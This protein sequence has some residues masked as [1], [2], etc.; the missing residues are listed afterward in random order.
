MLIEEG[1]SDRVL[2]RTAGNLIGYTHDY[3][4]GLPETTSRIGK[5]TD[6]VK[7]VNRELPGRDQADEVWLRWF[8][9]FER[10]LSPLQKVNTELEKTAR[11]LRVRQRSIM[12]SMSPAGMFSLI[13]STAHFFAKPRTSR[14]VTPASCS[15]V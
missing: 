14:K 12:P 15:S 7:T 6:F 1:T 10:L 5:Y 2:Y 3:L 9:K 11:R 13:C 4:I 8:D